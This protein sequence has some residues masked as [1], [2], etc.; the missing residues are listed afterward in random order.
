M[1]VFLFIGHDHPPHSMARRDAVR[2]EHRA[3]VLDH[4]AM[5]RFA[6]AMVDGQGNQCGTVIAFE[7]ADAAQVRQWVED[8]PFHRHGVYARTEVVEWRLAFNRFD[9]MDWA[10]PRPSHES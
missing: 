2:A 1:S 8:E 4:D 5:I 10:S 9:R 3:Y 6:G 7:A